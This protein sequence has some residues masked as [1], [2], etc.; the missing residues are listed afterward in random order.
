MKLLD[1]VIHIEQIE[2]GH[3]Y[4]YTTL[5][6]LQGILDNN[7]FWVTKSDFLNDKSEFQYTYD[8]FRNNF[9]CNITELSFRKKLINEFDALINED[10]DI[11]R[12]PLNG[13]Y[14]ASF[15]TDS[16]NLALWSEFS[17][18]MGYNLE[19]DA[20]PFIRSFDKTIMWHGKVVYDKKKQLLLLKEALE[21]AMTWRTEYGDAKSLSDFFDNTPDSVTK[22]I[23]LDLYAF[24]TVYAMFFKQ[25]E[26]NLESEYRVV[27]SSIHEES[28][29]VKNPES[30]FFRP[31]K[32]IL[33]PYIKVH[34]KAMDSL[35]AIIVGPKNNIDIATAGISMYC[36]SKGIAIPI[37][38][39]RIPLR[40]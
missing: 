34:C 12:K 8:L 10:N 15:S 28:N 37:R 39:S 16:D 17:N 5:N 24:C 33:I 1:D 40:Y 19:I 27:L 9:L 31:A 29:Y 14:I 36:R 30:L 20:E 32:E 13:Y 21:K 11:S 18:A 38:K 22:C 3:I 26:F 7:E 4:H 25:P 35:K 23:A 2:N 6:A